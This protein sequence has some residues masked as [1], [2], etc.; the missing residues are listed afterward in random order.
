MKQGSESHSSTLC[1]ISSTYAVVGGI[2]GG[3]ERK[4]WRPQGAAE[5]FAG[6]LTTAPSPASTRL[7]YPLVVVFN[8][9]APAVIQNA[10]LD[11]GSP[12]QEEKSAKMNWND[13]P[14]HPRRERFEVE[15]GRGLEVRLMTSST[16]AVYLCSPGVPFINGQTI[17]VDG[18]WSWELYEKF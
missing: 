9:F 16:V 1:I 5:V 4:Y 14:Q 8:E 6:P 7:R 10:A 13:P 11:R 15:V 2:R 12:W 3:W 18:G 17:V